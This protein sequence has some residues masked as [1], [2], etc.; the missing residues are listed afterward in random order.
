[1]MQVQYRENDEWK[2]A[3]DLDLVG[4][5]QGKAVN[6]LEHVTHA[7]ETHSRRLVR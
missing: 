5:Q 3:R 1:M 6:K 7:A 2:L 4:E